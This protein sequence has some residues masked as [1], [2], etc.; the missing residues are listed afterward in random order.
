MFNL[1]VG[2][3]TAANSI[4]RRRGLAMA[5]QD[6]WGERPESDKPKQQSGKDE[7]GPPDLD[8][9]FSKL[10]KRKPKR[11][12]GDDQSGGGG[13]PSLPPMSGKLIA[14]IAGAIVAAWLATGFYTIQER[15]NGVEI[16]LGKYAST[17][18]SGL[19]WNWPA[20][21]GKVEKV[22]VTSISTMRVGEFKTQSGN[23]STTSQR[24]GQMLTS[25][26]N[27]VEIGAAVQYR[28]GDAK[29]FLFQAENPVD[30]LEDIVISAIREVVGANGVDD[31]LRDKRSFWPQEAKDIIVQTLQEYDLGFEIIAFELQDARAP[32]E[33]Q[34]AFEDAV[35]AREDEERS[36][37]KAEAVARER[38]PQA[39]GEAAT[40]IEQAKEYR[41]NVLADANANVSRFDDLL[42]AYR[43]DKEVV[44]N[45]LYLDTMGDVFS[46]VPKII[47]DAENAQ[48]IV[49]LGNN[50]Q[51]RDESVRSSVGA[52]SVEKRNNESG[53]NRSSGNR[54]DTGRQS[55]TQE[56]D[57]RSRERPQ[58]E[59]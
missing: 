20:P 52:S 36:R 14:L 17:S 50:Q 40:M 37:L 8:E 59:Y 2:C 39:R 25:D 56:N 31:I 28:I 29:Q 58:R 7:Q 32:A 46:S 54:S 13:T 27:I 45:Q 3:Y 26:E 51:Q 48:P 12:G 21:I 57:L 38:L 35:R 22:D 19:N 34:D 9:L 43:L 16:V 5:T 10:I 55:S 53:D 47:V 49:N 42:A 18:K 11:S 24:V 1:L 44:R 15:E 6:P 30:M 4:A 33:V 41:A 23:T